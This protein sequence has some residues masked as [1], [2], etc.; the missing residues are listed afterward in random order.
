MNIHEY[1]SKVLQRLLLP[2]NEKKKEKK[3]LSKQILKWCN[4]YEYDSFSVKVILFFNLGSGFPLE[5]YFEYN[6]R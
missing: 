5:F 3:R 2:L 1:E 4:G 6:N